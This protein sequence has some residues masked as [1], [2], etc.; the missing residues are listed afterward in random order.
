MLALASRL[1]EAA[2]KQSTFVRTKLTSAALGITM[3]EA[4]QEIESV[5]QLTPSVVRILGQNPGKFTLQGTNTYLITPQQSESGSGYLSSVL[6]DTGEGNDAY[7]AAL[8][9]VL[10]GKDDRAGP[11]KRVVTDVILTHWHRDHVGGLPSVLELLH[12]LGQEKPKI[13]KFRTTDTDGK[14]WDQIKDRMPLSLDESIAR[15]Q[16][17]GTLSFGEDTS[18]CTLQV[19]HA[20][21]HTADHICL[22]MSEEG[23]M[24]TGDHVLGQGTSVF[25]DLASY[26]RSLQKCKSVVEKIPSKDCQLFPGHGPQVHNGYEALQKYLTHRLDRER[27]ILELLSRPSEKGPVRWTIPQIVSSLYSGY[28]ESLFPAAARGIFLHLQKLAMPDDEAVERRAVPTHRPDGTLHDGRRVQCQNPDLTATDSDVIR[29]LPHRLAES[30]ILMEL[31]WSL[32]DD[33]KVVRTQ[34]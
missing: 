18:T 22:M 5:T 23:V 10:Q 34:L 30:P 27:Q 6:I 12:D 11:R 24:F 8:K 29:K 19:I 9:D 13:H 26:L 15:L 4:L 33:G 20:P 32:L 7:V 3:T 2:Y 14:V 25:E 21:G 16:D 28:P 1:V 31:K 17:G